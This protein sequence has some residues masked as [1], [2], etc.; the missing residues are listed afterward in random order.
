MPEVP[1]SF[2]MACFAFQRQETKWC[3]HCRSRPKSRQTTTRIPSGICLEHS[4][5]TSV[6]LKEKKKQIFLTPKKAD[7]WIL[8]TSLSKLMLVWKKKHAFWIGTNHPTTMESESG[9]RA[10][11][12]GVVKNT[13]F[14]EQRIQRRR[15]G[16]GW[17]LQEH[18]C[19]GLSVH[20]ALS[21]WWRPGASWQLGWTSRLQPT[22]VRKGCSNWKVSQITFST[23]QLK[24]SV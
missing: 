13:H 12:R 17:K 15:K 9:I 3:F 16:S 22:P 8:L 21:A 23:C 6:N 7:L 18:C 14:A 2:W 24:M 11:T 20:A 19:W 10:I 5:A 4:W 1:P